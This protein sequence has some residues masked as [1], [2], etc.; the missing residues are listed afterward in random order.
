MIIVKLFIDT[1]SKYEFNFIFFLIEVLKKKNKRCIPAITDDLYFYV[2]SF[3][4]EGSMVK[5]EFHSKFVTSRL[6]QNIFGKIDLH[7]TL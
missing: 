3:S 2:A 6:N 4:L 7:D 1:L 5:K